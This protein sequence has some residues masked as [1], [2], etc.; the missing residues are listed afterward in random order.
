MTVTIKIKVDYKSIKRG[1][2]FD[3]PNFCVLTGKNGSGKSHLLEAISNKNLSDVTVNSLKI[4]YIKHVP[5]NG[6]NPTIQGSCDPDTINKYVK[7]TWRNFES[8]KDNISP[9]HETITNQIVL[10]YVSDENQKRFISSAL[11]STNKLYDQLTENDLMNSFEPSYVG[12]NDFFTAQFAMIFKNYHRLLLENETNKFYESEGIP[13]TNSVLTDE[14]FNKKNGKPPWKFVNEIFKETGIPYE[15][16]DPMGDRLESSFAFKL[17]DKSNGFEIN[18][19]DLSTGEKVLMSLTA[20]VYNTADKSGKPGLL[21]IDEPDAAL[22]PSMT[23]KMV[24]ILKSKVVEGSGI[25]TIITTHSPITAISAEGLAMYQLVRGESVPTKISTQEAVELLSGDIPFLKVSTEKRR[26]VFVESK[27]D[28]E[29]Y[30]L[31]TN[32]YAKEFTLPAEPIFIPARTSNGSNCD[33]V[34]SI[35]NN[36]SEHGNN[37][38]YGIIDWDLKNQSSEKVLVLGENDRY[39]IENYLLDPLLMGLLFIRENKMATSEFENLSI[40]K[41]SEVRELTINDAQIIV[42]K[43]LTDLKLQCKHKVKYKLL[44]SWEL[45]ITKEFNELKGH[46]LEEYYISKFP[47]LKLY[48]RGNALKK[49]V[50]EKVISDYPGFSPLALSEALMKIK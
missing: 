26:S 37:Q 33:D 18:P 2:E 14:E 24:S 16:N 31:L 42:D 25:P 34:I 28:A 27:Y 30:S 23:R 7:D 49:D 43:V 40:T 45:Q 35:V 12:K 32:I 20:A 38:V 6:L 13:T 15:A 10:Q 36:L 9:K 17:K 39:T 48:I 50:I 11:E 3:L 46:V 4:E 19:S 1:E 22:H 21:L 5:F 8:A 41:Y 44:N 29:Y 47:F